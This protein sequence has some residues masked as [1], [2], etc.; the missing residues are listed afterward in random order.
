MRERFKTES[1]R[2]SD[3]YGRHELDQG[4]LRYRVGGAEPYARHGLL[5]FGEEFRPDERGK[6]V[7]RGRERRAGI[8]E[9]YERP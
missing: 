8:G 5:S 3:C 4:S 2:R 9:L 1:P 7:F 6:L